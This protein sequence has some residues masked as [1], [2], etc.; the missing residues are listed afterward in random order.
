MTTKIVK[1]YALADGSTLLLGP[2][3]Q[4][5]VTPRPAVM[6]STPYEEARRLR[7][8]AERIEVCGELCLRDNA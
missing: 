6:G 5:L 2:A 7:D 3:G 8:Y 4:R 1:T